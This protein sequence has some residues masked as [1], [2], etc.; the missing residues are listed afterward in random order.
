MQSVLPVAKLMGKHQVQVLSHSRKI[1][2]RHN[3]L[4]RVPRKMLNRMGRKETRR[5]KLVAKVEQQ[6]GNRRKCKRVT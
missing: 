1:I 2:K 6:V 5:V 4:A 3:L